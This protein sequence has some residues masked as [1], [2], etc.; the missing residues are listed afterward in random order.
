MATDT[1]KTIQ[2]EW[3]ILEQASEVDLVRDLH[4]LVQK[5]PALLTLTG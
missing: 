4:M 2:I 1:S 5:L 3:Q